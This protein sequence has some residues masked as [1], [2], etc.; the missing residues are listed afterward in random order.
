[1]MNQWVYAGF[2]VT[3]KELGVDF[4]KI[5]YESETYLY[6]KNEVLRGLAEGVFYQK[7]DSSVWADLTAE[8]LDQKILLRS[9]GTSV[10]MTQDIGTAKER[11]EDYPI[12]KMVYVVGNE[13]NYHFQVLSI[14]LDKLGFEFGK[15]LHHF[16]YGMVELP[17]GKMKS[18]EGT[19]VDADDLMAEMIEVS[20][21]TSEELGKLEGYTPEQARETYRMI[22]LGALKY[23]MLKVDPKKNML[24]NPEESIDFNGNTGPFI[25]YAYARIRSVLRKAAD[26]GIELNHAISAEMQ[27]GAKEMSLIKA[28]SQFPVAIKEAGDLYSPA[29]IANYIYELVKEFNQ[30]YHEF[31]MLAEENA[32]VRN[33]RLVIAETVG[34]TIKTGMSLLGISVPER[35]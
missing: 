26:K 23:F 24:F 15:G 1:M 3:Y 20:R 31:P 19:V 32:D 28:I 21:K 25:Q 30:F 2:D 5:Y 17:Q 14:L 13:Q 9:D 27:A 18:R 29:I 7:E 16:S 4:D 22:A 11:F 33:L 12:D 10:Y 6:G 35:M 34:K 8:G